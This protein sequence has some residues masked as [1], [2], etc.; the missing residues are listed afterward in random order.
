MP[1]VLI[2]GASTGIGKAT[3]LQLARSGW[4]VL[5]GVRNTAA[6]EA[7]VTQAGSGGRLTPV[8]LDI[9][10]TA[11]IANS[12]SSLLSEQ[13]RFVEAERHVKSP[14][15]VQPERDTVYST[16]RGLVDLSCVFDADVHARPDNRTISHHH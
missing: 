11:Q 15:I 12:L 4:D 14:R 13:S 2:T 6:G 7:L 9:T 3:A 5:A 16:R 10:D 1:T 8:Q